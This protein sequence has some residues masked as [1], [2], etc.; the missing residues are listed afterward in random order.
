MLSPSSEQ[1]QG[2]NQPRCQRRGFIAQ[3]PARMRRKRH[4]GWSIF[5]LSMYALRNKRISHGH[6]QWISFLRHPDVAI[7]VH[8]L[9]S[10]LAKNAS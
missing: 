2:Q 8:H 9:M 4:K 5:F 6:W 7:P 3:D 10:A 1:R